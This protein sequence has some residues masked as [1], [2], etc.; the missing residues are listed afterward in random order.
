[1]EYKKLEFITKKEA[2]EIFSTSSD[3]FEIAEAIFRMVYFIED[4]SFVVVNLVILA[5]TNKY[6][7]QII[8]CLSDFTRI[9]WFFPDELQELLENYKNNPDYKSFS[10]EIEEDIKIL[11]KAKL[12]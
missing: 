10:E 7:H 9:H 5:K 4:D 1:M 8:T 2:E 11:L 6:H 3:E 12:W